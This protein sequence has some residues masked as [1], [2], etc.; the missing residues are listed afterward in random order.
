MAV[1]AWHYNDVSGRWNE[2]QG[3]QELRLAC[4]HCGHTRTGPRPRLYEKYW[5]SMSLETYDAGVPPFG[6]RLWLEAEC[7]GGH[8]LWALNREH[9][10]YLADYVAETQRER[11]F[12]SPSGN[13]QLAYKLPKWMKLAKNREEILR[14]VARLRATL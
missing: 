7:C 13:R 5:P 10:D 8:T 1:V 2:V 6:A 12:P 14:V 3:F 4:G 9:L 11:E